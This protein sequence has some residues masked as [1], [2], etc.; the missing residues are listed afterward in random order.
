MGSGL[1]FLGGIF[2]VDWTGDRKELR[3]LR[4][5][6]CPSHL[7]LSLIIFWLEYEKRITNQRR[8]TRR[9]E[10]AGSRSNHMAPRFVKYFLRDAMDLGYT[11]PDR[12]ACPQRNLLLRP[13]SRVVVCQLSVANVSSAL[14]WSLVPQK[15]THYASKAPA[16]GDV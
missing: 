2:K 10:V 8:P 1:L 6:Q 16:E 3:F 12:S 15:T 14:A 11:P 7:L 13:L 4:A 5:W 9:T